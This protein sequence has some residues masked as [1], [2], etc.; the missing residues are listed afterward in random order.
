MSNITEKDLIELGF[1]REVV[2]PE[3]S[4]EKKKFHYF[5]L[6]IGELCLITN[7]N[8]E[9]IDHKY[10]VEFF[11]YTNVGYFDDFDIVKNLI[12]LI[13]SGKKNI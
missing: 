2:L 13:K 4:G 7:S 3:E 1:T 6:D 8:D 5:V 10:K 9:C 12:K 11:D